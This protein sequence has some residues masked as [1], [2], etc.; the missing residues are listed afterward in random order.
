MYTAVFEN[1]DRDMDAGN[2]GLLMD[3]EKEDLR[4]VLGTIVLAAEPLS[5]EAIASISRVDLDTTQGLLT[6][7][8]AVLEISD[9]DKQPVRTVHKSFSDFLLRKP[10]RGTSWFHVDGTEL[11]DHIAEGCM[12]LMR[13]LRKDICEIGD[14]GVSRESI[15][16][17]TI[18]CHISKSLQYASSYW[19]HHLQ[20]GNKQGLYSESLVIVLETHFLHW[21]ECL[22]ILDRPP[23]ASKA[24][25]ELCTSIIVCK[26]LSAILQ[27]ELTNDT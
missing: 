20:S 11:H 19:W 1:L 6:L 22:S 18:E 8:R 26:T 27:G 10:T 4:I 16:S 13:T 7:C 25:K 24:I 21:I 9:D 17:E 23:Y 2:S 12:C 3:E 15:E 14:P 5:I